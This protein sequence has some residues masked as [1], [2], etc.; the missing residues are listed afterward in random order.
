MTPGGPGGGLTGKGCLHTASGRSTSP[1][2]SF[3]QLTALLSSRTEG[4]PESESQVSLS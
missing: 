4:S 3:G 1:R 2:S